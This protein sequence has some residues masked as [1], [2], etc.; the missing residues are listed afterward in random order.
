MAEKEE[1]KNY[2]VKELGEGEDR[3]R[4]LK[5][6]KLF[7]DPEKFKVIADSTRW[8]V[9]KSISGE[10]KYPSQIA[11]EL[12]LNEQKVYYH[13]N[14]LEKAGLIEVVKREERSGSLAK[15]YRSRES[16]FSIELPHGEEKPLREP[17]S[18]QPEQVKNFLYPFIKNGEINTR[19]IVGSPDPHGPNQVRGRD[20]HLAIQL[21]LFLGQHGSL[22]KGFP[23]EL[24]TEAKGDK[25]GNMILLGGPLTNMFVKKINEH[26]L[27]NFSMDKF[28]YHEL[29]SSKTGEKYT[30]KPIGTI[31][32]T[33]NPHDPDNSI[34]ALSGIGK[35]GTKA[36]LLALTLK[37]EEVLE[38]Y[39][40]ED[41]W[42]RVV[43][44]LD[45]DGD[46]KIDDV[47]ILE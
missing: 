13:V 25:K 14:Q 4:I 33:R 16:A 18:E 1:K 42:G 27:V 21:G 32:R 36:T 12:G 24:D 41:K 6:T 31:A 34:L 44:G 38:D 30:E 8:M 11:K 47:E 40:N 43:R 10:S 3:H 23:T 35:S 28:P 20:N 46:G 2:L 37:T 26:L 5:E 22:E 15:Y 45:L 29:N 7:K 39:D 17:L 19:I 9:L